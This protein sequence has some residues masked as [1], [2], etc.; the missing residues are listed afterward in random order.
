[1]ASKKQIG[2]FWG[3]EFLSVAE[4]QRDQ[5]IFSAAIPRQIPDN[6]N[7]PLSAEGMAISE[8]VHLTAA[9]LRLIK[10]R[11]IDKPKMRL[12]I[13]VRDIIFRSFTI[14][15]MSPLETENAI[16]FEAPRYMPFKLD[17]LFYAFHAIPFMEKDIKKNQIL[18]LAIR[19]DKLDQ[20]CKIIEDANAEILSVEPSILSLLRILHVKKLSNATQTIAIVQIIEGQGSIMVVNQQIPHLI[21]NFNLLTANSDGSEQDFRSIVAN[22][23]SEIRNSIEFYNRQ[24]KAA[25]PSSQV[26]HIYLFTD[27]N[28]KETSQGIN[29]ELGI[30]ATS[31]N[32][33][34]LFRYENELHSNMANAIGISLTDTTPSSFNLDLAKSRKLKHSKVSDS[35]TKSFLTQTPNYKTTIIVAWICLSLGGGLYGITRSQAL[36][37]EK[38]FSEFKTFVQKYQ[39]ASKP[40]LEKMIVDVEAKTTD[41]KKLRLESH[42]TLYLKNISDALLDGAWLSN[43]NIGYGNPQETGRREIK[44]YVNL[45]GYSYDEKLN[46]QISLIEEFL[47]RLRSN[48]FFKKYSKKIELTQVKKETLGG[49]PVTFFEIII[50]TDE[51]NE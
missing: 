1:M 21:R 48:A 30:A 3:S 17:E 8:D 34:N 29:D 11:N 4:M 14:P 51:T 10:D 40:D 36:P 45:Q 15:F 19:Q 31:L 23:A 44:V 41:Y 5:L 28:A 27:Q 13:P 46:R 43:L 42:M 16:A 6:L 35:G 20:Y 2:I 50:E 47:E 9:I 33:N 12:S 39:N 22:L 32:L 38:K 18:F 37:L 25:N 49:F 26:T 7:P 24:P